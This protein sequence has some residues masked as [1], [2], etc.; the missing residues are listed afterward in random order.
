MLARPKEIKKIESSSIT[1]LRSVEK[2]RY[3][4][5]TAAQHR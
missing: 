1:W 3:Q 4:R 5:Y 2:L